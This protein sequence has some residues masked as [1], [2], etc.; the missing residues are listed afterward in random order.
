M[1]NVVGGWSAENDTLPYDTNDNYG[2]TPANTQ[3]AQ[4][5]Y[6]SGIGAIRAAS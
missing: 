3:P 1:R 5:A 4:N 6:V 2:G